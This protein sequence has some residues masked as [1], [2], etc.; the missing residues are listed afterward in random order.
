MRDHNQTPAIRTSLPTQFAVIAGTVLT[1][2]VVS[3]YAIGLVLSGKP[4]AMR[5]V[6]YNAPIAFVFSVLAIEFVL[7][8][9]RQGWRGLIRS[10]GASLLTWL[11]ATIVLL[12]RLG[13]TRIDVSGHLTWLPMLTADAWVRGLPVWFLGWAAA[14]TG[15]AIYLKFGVFGGPSGPPGILTGSVLAAVLLCNARRQQ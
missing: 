4:D 5:Q 15:L 10:R 7:I 6:F 13:P 9:S 1:I 2:V 11:V 14:A 3:L 8:W 12:L